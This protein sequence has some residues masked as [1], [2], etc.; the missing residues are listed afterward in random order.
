[1]VC[2]CV[3]GD[4][5]WRWMR[6]HGG[7]TQGISG[8]LTARARALSLSLLAVSACPD[9]NPFEGPCGANRVLKPNQTD[10]KEK[11]ETLGPSQ[12]LLG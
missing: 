9:S 5:G 3:L 12:L 8:Q 7:D 1:M 10:S 11:A 2:M 6:R 4:G